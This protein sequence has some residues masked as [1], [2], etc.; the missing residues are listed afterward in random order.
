MTA[1]TKKYYDSSKC[2]WIEEKNTD[3]SENE[4]S[5]TRIYNKLSAVYPM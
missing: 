4:K 5:G 2:A 1:I 3:G